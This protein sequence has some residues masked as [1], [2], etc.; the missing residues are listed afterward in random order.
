ML[1]IHAEFHFLSKYQ[2][3]DIV[4]H[5]LYC[6]KWD[7]ISKSCCDLVSGTKGI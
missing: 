1:Y 2:A 5:S 7:K 3:L 4:P 6:S